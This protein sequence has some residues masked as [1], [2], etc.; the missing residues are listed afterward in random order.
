RRSVVMAAALVG[1]TLCWSQAAGAASV[2]SPPSDVLAPIW[3]PAGPVASVVRVG[4]TV[5][6]GGGFGVLTPVSGHAVV[7]ARSNGPT[8]TRWPVIDGDVHA[9]ASDGRGGFFLGGSFLHADGAAHPGLVHVTAAGSVDA[10]FDPL[11]NGPVDTLAYAGG[12]L[13]AGGRFNTV[14]G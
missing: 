5:F 11:L 8:A 9:A 2:G 3:A 10:G 7:Y 12:R 13:Y 1:A 6:V 14:D 4:S